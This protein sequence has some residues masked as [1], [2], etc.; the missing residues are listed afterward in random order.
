MLNYFKSFNR[1]AF[2]L[3]LLQAYD[4][5]REQ[6]DFNFFLKTGKINSSNNSSWHEIIQSAIKRNAKFQRVR[7][8]QEPLSKYLQYEFEHYKSNIKAGDKVF[9]LKKEEFKKL[10]SDINFDFWLF[11]DEIVLKMNYDSSGKFLGFEVLNTNI[12]PFIKLKNNLLKIA[13][14]FEDY[15]SA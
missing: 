12:E 11:D 3:E 13:K 7:V 4:V 5:S 15:R 14:S 8:I 2:R 10:N 1:Y 9:L 6:E